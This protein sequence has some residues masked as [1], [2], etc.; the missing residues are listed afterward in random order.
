MPTVDGASRM[1]LRPEVPGRTNGTNAGGDTL[2]S[3]QF[4]LT[5]PSCSNNLMA[6]DRFLSYRVCGDCGRH[7]SI[8][9]RERVALLVDSGVFQELDAPAEDPAPDRDRLPPAER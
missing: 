5:C 8:G 7:F 9:A 4:D 2:D 1:H 3:E 6:D